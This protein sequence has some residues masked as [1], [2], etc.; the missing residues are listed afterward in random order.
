MNG[1]TADPDGVLEVR[2][3]RHTVAVHRPEKV[4]FPDAG[5]TGVMGVTKADLA[6]YY[7]RMALFMLPQLKDRPLML[8]RLPD[9]VKG[10]RFVQKDTPE[11]WPEWVRR[12][13]VEKE[14]G[15]VRHMVCDDGATLVLLADQACLTLHRWLSR[16]DRLPW[17]DRLVFDLDP[18][19]E[20]FGAVRDAARWLRELLEEL[21]VPSAPMTTGSKGLH[22]VV[23]L[24]GHTTFEESRSFAKEVAE[25]LAGRHP[26]RLTTAV[27]KRARGDRLYLDVQ[28]NG[29]A[30]TAVAPWSPR[31]RAGAPVAV[32]VSWEQVEDPGV[33]A[34]TWS[35][36]DVEGVLEQA[37]RNP[38]AGVMGKGR[39]LGPAR[40]RLAGVSR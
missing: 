18:P 35:L 8:E 12:V 21:H 32:P 26:E 10:P 15:T 5:A 24:N 14:G 3:G 13:T 20:D 16:T 11:N 27:R 30:Q 40:K 19:T 23:P 22:V 31:A 28:R 33:T 37:R 25:L 34:R 7:R 38:W 6:A 1:R 39:G 17:P 2:V 4:L 29:Y 9:G 36:G